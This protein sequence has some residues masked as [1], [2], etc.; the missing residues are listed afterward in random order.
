[1]IRASSIQSST[2]VTNAEDFDASDPLA[3]LPTVTY[4]LKHLTSFQGVLGNDIGVV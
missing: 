2:Q 4:L 3:V 1:M